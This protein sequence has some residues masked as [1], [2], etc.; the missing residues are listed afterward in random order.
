MQYDWCLNKKNKFGHRDMYRGNA[1]LRNIRRRH[2]SPS[3]VERLEQIPSSLLSEG[4]KPTDTFTSD[5][6]LPEL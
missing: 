4:T 2:P 6:W 3:Q 5:F 1:M